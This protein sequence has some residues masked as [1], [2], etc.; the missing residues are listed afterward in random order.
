MS[1]ISGL[2]VVIFASI[3]S[4]WINDHVYKGEYLSDEG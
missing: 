1:L 4:T 3:I 2:V